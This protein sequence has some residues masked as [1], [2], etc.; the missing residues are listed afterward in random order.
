G[1]EETVRVARG[2]LDGP[3]TLV[4]NDATFFADAAAGQKTG[5]FF[6]QRD[7]RAFVAGLARGRT[8]LDLYTYAG[9]F[10]VLAALHGAKAVT[11]I[12]RSD[13][14]LALAIRAA[15]VNGV[16]SVCHFEK[17]EVFAH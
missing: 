15:E 16:A 7:S 14:S 17:R 5:W 12:D 11:A 9:G 8:V 13:A 3:I 4:E 10:A 6:D 1:L 2:A